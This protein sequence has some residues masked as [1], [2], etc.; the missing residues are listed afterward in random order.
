MDTGETAAA[1][2][3]G[4]GSVGEAVDRVD[5]EGVCGHTADVNSGAGEAPYIGQTSRSCVV[6]WLLRT[7]AV[8][9]ASMQGGWQARLAVVWVALAGQL[10]LDRQEQYNICALSS[11]QLGRQGLQVVVVA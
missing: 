9:R 7:E 5:G 1:A 4:T 3:C 8:I 11:G 10:N 6:V 2:F